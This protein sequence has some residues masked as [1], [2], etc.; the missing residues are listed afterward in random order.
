M[1]LQSNHL[2]VA[3]KTSGIGPFPPG[4]LLSAYSNYSGLSGFVKWAIS[5]LQGFHPYW[6]IS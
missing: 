2:N 3:S 1:T 5:S 6:F 4:S